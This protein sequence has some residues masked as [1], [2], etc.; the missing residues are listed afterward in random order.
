M[1]LITQIYTDYKIMASLQLH[2]LRVAGVA[3]MIC[4]HISNDLP[5]KLDKENVIKACLLHDMGN[6][7]K[8]NL[9]IFPEFLKPQGKEYWQEVKDEFERKYGTK[10]HQATL[11]IVDEI[12]G[13]E[14]IRELIDAVSFVKQ[15]ENFESTDFG[16]KICAYADMRVIP[17]TV[18]SLDERMK[19]GKERYPQFNSQAS[20]FRYVFAYLKKTEKQIFEQCDIQ[21]EDIS[22]ETVE[23]YFDQLKLVEI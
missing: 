7:L 18:T 20:G 17:T 5:E 13:S 23:K 8:F 15:K 16:K 2:M 22:E 9:D 19:D 12:G 11:Q 4:D 10:V 6:I 3:A 21:P 1:A 14:R